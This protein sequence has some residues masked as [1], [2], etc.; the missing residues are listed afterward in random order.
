MPFTDRSDIFGAVHEEGINRVVEHIMRQRP[1]LFNYATRFFRHRPDLLCTPIKAAQ[2]VLD[3]GN[4]LFTEQD[5]LPILGAPIP[6]GL[7][8]C[9][10]LTDFQ[11]DFHPANTITLP[12]ELAP[13]PAQRLALRFRA[14]AGIDCPSDEVI[15]DFIRLMEEAA[16][17]Q[18]DIVVKPPKSRAAQLAAGTRALPSV[19]ALD[20]P[21]AALT[22]IPDR[23]RDVVVNLP[24]LVLDP[25]GRDTKPTLPT[26]SL[27]C[28]CLELFAVAHFEWGTI[29]SHPRQWLKPRLD[30]IEI[31]DMQP[32]PLE[33]MIEC[34]L[35]TVLRLGI[36]PRL[37]V[38]LEAMILDITAMLAQQGLAIGQQV[39]L[40]PAPISAQ[41][42]H[43]PAIE[44]EQL[45]A[46][47]NL[48][49]E[50]A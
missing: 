3:A 6:I 22:R 24:D 33:N 25:G 34:Y 28:V 37:V 26:R 9:I 39:S 50:E 36:L 17:R 29:G 16:V 43:N 18:G 7:N 14:C 42:P 1:S 40:Q 5:P 20:V 12:P 19:R 4:P 2:K 49:V 21:T 27:T 31:V 44:Q 41:L 15:A 10:Q 8:Y 11:I 38:P 32:T 45:K 23:L 30:G 47:I 35:K 46:F 48:I 13:L